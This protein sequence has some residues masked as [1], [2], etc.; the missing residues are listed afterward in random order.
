[1]DF[2]KSV[3]T[4]GWLSI[5]RSYILVCSA[6]WKKGGVGKDKTLDNIALLAMVGLGSKGIYFVI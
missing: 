1:M 2:Q 3:G 6:L 4:L 5:C